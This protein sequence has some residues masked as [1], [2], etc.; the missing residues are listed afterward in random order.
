MFWYFV[1]SLLWIQCLCSGRHTPHT[2]DLG[3]YNLAGSIVGMRVSRLKF[4]TWKF[5]SI[6]IHCG[7]SFFQDLEYWVGQA[8]GTISLSQNFTVWLQHF[9]NGF[10]Y[11]QIFT[12]NERKMTLC[13]LLPWLLEIKIVLIELKASGPGHLKTLCKFPSM[14]WNASFELLQFFSQTIKQNVS[15]FSDGSFGKF[16]LDY[17]WV[18]PSAF[19]LLMQTIRINVDVSD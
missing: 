16:I 6:H 5:A 3:G 17:P 14:H 2:G 11:F 8:V 1:P 12:S 18:L 10:S 7:P 13:H 19:F 15:S 9:W 4:R